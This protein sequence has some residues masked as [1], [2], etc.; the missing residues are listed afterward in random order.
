MPNQTSANGIFPNESGVPF[1]KIVT[2]NDY[3]A[4]FNEYFYVK[5]THITRPYSSLFVRAH[6]S[7]QFTD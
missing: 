7:A 4:P 3:Y 6:L 2:I 1:A 5:I